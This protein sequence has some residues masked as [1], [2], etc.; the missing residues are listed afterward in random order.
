MTTAVR[1][2]EAEFRGAGGVRLFERRWLPA[3][4]PR[5]TLAIVHGYAEHSG[6][7]D[8]AGRA[9]AAR[10]F[11]VAALDL[12]GHGRSARA[13][14]LVRSAGEYVADVRIFLRRA[15]AIAP[16]APLFLLGHS[17]GGGIVTLAAVVDRPHVDGIILSGAVLPTEERAPAP[18]RWLLEALAR[19]WPSLPLTK[20]AAADVSRDAD[21]VRTYDAD[22]LVYRGRMKAV[23]LAAMLRAG[24]RIDAGEA[25]IALPLLILHGTADALVGTE[26]SRRLYER[27]SSVD[28]AL[29]LY[30]GLY[31]EI[32][33]EP[34]R[35][36]VID[37]IASWMEAR[38][39]VARATHPGDAARDA[40]ALRP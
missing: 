37:D 18:L 31:H 2:E 15:S 1:I 30:D 19:A 13:R 33:N 34:E 39:P 40:E 36:Q 16:E 14:A 9:F 32:L 5:A 6:R 24:E 22:P 29:K 7:Y 26:G 23:L 4:E 3:G 28:K 38:S 11:A 21:V 35:D 17:M 12:R 25:S 10:G 8:Y 27:A 20:L